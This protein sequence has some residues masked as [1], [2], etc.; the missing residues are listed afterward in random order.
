[1]NTDPDINF[2]VPDAPGAP[3]QHIIE[4][5]M[6]PL[7]A[8]LPGSFVSTQSLP[9][10]VN[11]HF[12]KGCTYRQRV[13]IYQ[14]TS[15]FMP[16]SLADPC[17]R[18]CQ[19]LHDYDYVCVSGPLS[20]SLSLAHGVPT[21]KTLVTG[22]SKLDPFF[23]GFYNKR[24]QEDGKPVVLYAP[25]HAAVE[26]SSYPAFVPFLKLFPDDLS[27][28][29]SPHPVHK[30]NCLPALQELADADIVISD[31]S[32]IVYEAWALGKPVV[33]P[34][35]LCSPAVLQTWPDSLVL[36]VYR[37]NIGYHASRFSHLI[38][39]VYQAIHEGMKE[40]E[41]RF[42]DE[43]LP[44]YLRGHSGETAAAALMKLAG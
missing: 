37:N 2:V 12:F 44:P 1:M 28:I 7:R 17:F 27:V 15:V 24:Q 40:E 25:T 4:T 20:A 21:E 3:Y 35:W 9:G 41:K 33:F 13:D 43:L 39:L 18:D 30:K 36:R 5:I 6:N 16:C 42:I 26:P 34:A 29:Y 10:T 22:F 23:Q 31:C 19:T 8:C 14:G 11:V 32:S 38:D